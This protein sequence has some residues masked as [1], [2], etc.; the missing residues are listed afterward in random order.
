[1]TDDQM[2]NTFLNIG[3]HF[4]TESHSTC[5]SPRDPTDVMKM[6]FFVRMDYDVFDRDLIAAQENPSSTPEE[7]LYTVDICCIWGTQ[8]TIT[9]SD[10]RSAENYFDKKWCWDD[11]ED[12]TVLPIFVS[13]AIQGGT[14][15]NQKGFDAA[16]HHANEELEVDMW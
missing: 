9:R 1:M 8:I 14:F 12:A 4:C 7:A 2:I 16:L 10:G 5:D 3:G 11:K 13:E 6:K 15:M